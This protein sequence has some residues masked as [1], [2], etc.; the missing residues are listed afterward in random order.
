[1]TLSNEQLVLSNEEKKKR[2]LLVKSDTALLE[3][4]RTRLLK[5]SPNEAMRSW[6]RVMKGKAGGLIGPA[7]AYRT[8][9]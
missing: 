3:S 1:M 8:F 7:G 6:F 2:H 9:G 5:A 4:G